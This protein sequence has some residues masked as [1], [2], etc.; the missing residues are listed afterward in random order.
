MGGGSDVEHLPAGLVAVLARPHLWEATDKIAVSFAR[1][2]NVA[3]FGLYAAALAGALRA[4]RSVRRVV[5]Y[6]AISGAG[7]VVVAA[8]TQGNLGTAFRHRGQ[9]LWALVVV[10]VVGLLSRRSDR[11]T[12]ERV[13]A[14]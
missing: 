1:L 8:L 9:I 12:V 2:E 10:A 3:W 11:R 13:L 5:A 6:P 4:P 7:I 14:S